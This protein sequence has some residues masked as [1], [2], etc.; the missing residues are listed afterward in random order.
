MNKLAD[1][2]RHCRILLVDDHPIFR[3]GVM[4]ML[5]GESTYEVVAE[6]GSAQEAIS[7]LREADPD[8]ALVDI[9]LPGSNGIELIKMLLAEKP[10]LPILILTMHDE[11]VYAMRALRAGARGYLMKTE[12]MNGIV[13]AIHKVSTGEMYVSED[14]SNRL[15]FQ[16]VHGSNSEGQS[17]SPIDRLSDRELE[18]FRLLGR[19]FATRHIAKEL[20]LSIKTVETHRAHIK[21]KLGC[22]DSTEMVGF[23]ID[24]VTNENL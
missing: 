6:A 24:W 8:L 10:K 21:E 7:Q 3:R 4:S 18:V 1:N 14:L 22:S 13:E 9:S 17:Q 20:H 16:A 15:I 23:A 5:S 2:T 19:G 11:S 12:A